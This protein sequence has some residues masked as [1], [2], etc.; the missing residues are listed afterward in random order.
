[1]LTSMDL[2]LSNRIEIQMEGGS[3]FRDYNTQQAGKQ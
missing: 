1:M 2:I 3:A